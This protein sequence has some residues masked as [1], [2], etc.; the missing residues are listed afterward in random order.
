MKNMNERN[1]NRKPNRFGIRNFS[2]PALKVSLSA[3]ILPVILAA[4]LNPVQDAKPPV[5]GRVLVSLGDGGGR[6]LLPP[7]TD[8]TK[9]T[10]VFS[11]GEKTVTMDLTGDDS[12]TIS[13]G[14][15]GVDLELGTWNLTVSAYTGTAP[16]YT[17]TAESAEAVEIVVSWGSISV[18]KIWLIPVTVGNGT[19]SWDISFP[20]TMGTFINDVATLELK[21]PDGAIAVHQDLLAANLTNTATEKVSKG[22]VDIPVEYYD[23][24]IRLQK[25]EKLAGRA[26]LARIF[27]GLTTDAVFSFTED[28]FVSQK[29]LMGE[30]QDPAN[31]SG[32][33]LSDVRITAFDSDPRVAGNPISDPVTV[34]EG[35][36]ALKVPVDT[37][38]A[39]FKVEFH[40]SGNTPGVYETIEGPFNTTVTNEGALTEPIPPAAIIPFQAQVDDILYF[41]LEDAIEA[42]KNISATKSASNPVIVTLLE[43]ISLSSP[44]TISTG[45]FVKLVSRPA[46]GAGEGK[47]LSRATTDSLFTVETGGYLELGGDATLTINGEKG[48]YSAVTSALITVDGGAFTMTSSSIRENHDHGVY[49]ESGTFTMSGGSITGNENSGVGMLDGTFTLKG[50]NIGGELIEGNTAVSGGGVLMSGGI[51]EM[52]GGSIS[53]NASSGVASTD[54]TGGGVAVHG[55]TFTM[56]G[57]SIR[58]NTAFSLSGGSGG[59]VYV[60]AGDFD[61]QGGSI[62]GN[63]ART[64]SANDGYGGG[65]YK[66]GNGKFEMKGSAS[67]ASNEAGD[68]GGVYVAA[69]GFD[70]QG[71]SI[72]ENKANFSAVNNGN[73]GG[74]YVKNGRFYM[75]N[76]SSI[77]ENEAMQDGGGV[78]MENGAFTMD[79]GTS[80]ASN[81]AGQDGGG[82]LL[83]SSSNKEFKIQGSITGNSAQNGGGMFVELSNANTLYF[84]GII[85]GDDPGK[86]NTAVMGGGMYIKNYRLT[87]NLISNTSGFITGNTAST[88]GGGVYVDAV[89]FTVK[90]A[91]AI[92]GNT[93]TGTGGVPGLGGGV[94]V[95]GGTFNMQDT[96]SIKENEAGQDGGG[97]YVANAGIFTMYSTSFIKENEAGQ[98]GGG[99]YVNAGTF[100]MQDTSSIKENEAG[101]YGGGVYVANAG[102]FAMMHTSFMKKNEAGQ[103]GGGVY[104]VNAGSFVM[105]GATAITWNTASINGGG[106]YVDAGSFNMLNT[107]LIEKNMAGQDGGGVY[108]ADGNFDMGTYSSDSPSISENTASDGGGIYVANPGTVNFNQGSITGNTASTNGGGVYVDAGS[109]TMGGNSA[110]TGN[111][112]STNGGGVYVDAGSFTME[113]NSAITGNIASTNGGGVYVDAGNFKIGYSLS[114]NTSIFENTAINGGGM[115]VANPSGTVTFLYGSITGNTATG[116]GG[117]LGLGGGVYSKKTLANTSLVVDNTPDNYI[118]ISP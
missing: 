114:D 48:T 72:A 96:S 19:F 62:T 74:V 10:L 26:E 87:M 25:D 20:I 50:G 33:T 22:S 30:I 64:L 51:F 21:K 49:V 46:S 118:Y 15:Y 103:D 92:T 94:Y 67:I 68:G 107:S 14:G 89:S 65:V 69:G 12:K 44:I 111:T 102:S 91:T 71:G 104:V 5:L 29:Y 83:Y 88:N 45:T 70:M 75:Q 8:F 40:L 23:V 35:R 60:S 17:L 9:F 54:G 112:A 99:V 66:D 24:V 2:G 98:D 41:T 113:G 13:A 16:D 32:L 115:Y 86:G 116:T 84:A 3:F 55:G 6:S 4:C 85:G 18:Q 77:K 37:S 73:G 90:G 61:M 105:E 79:P 43:D 58:N 95:N 53:G 59:G 56:S 57:G 7:T 93:A 52:S 11:S 97:V 36:W 81:S 110:I 42:A 100:N 76:N 117:V 27:P 101:Q 78:Y 28:D 63:K 38:S 39:Y 106:V 1:D 34:T 31:T 80:I 47:T 109:F 82:M 108:V